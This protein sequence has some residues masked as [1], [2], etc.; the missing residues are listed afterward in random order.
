MACLP[1][2]RSQTSLASEAHSRNAMDANNAYP[3]AAARIHVRKSDRPLL[4]ASF[5]SCR[6]PVSARMAQSVSGQLTSYLIASSKVAV[7]SAFNPGTISSSP[8][9]GML[10]PE[11]K[12]L[13][14]AKSC[15]GQV[16]ERSSPT[17]EPSKRSCLLGTARSSRLIELRLRQASAPTPLF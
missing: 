12:D 16:L 14:G 9:Q 17:T 10:L 1:G 8:A 13:A 6:L 4:Q 3:Q 2:R 7:N 15:G 5:R 11:G